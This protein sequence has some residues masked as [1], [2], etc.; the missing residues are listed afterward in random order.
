[1]KHF[2]QKNNDGDDS[3][4]TTLDEE[5]PPQHIHDLFDKIDANSN[6]YLSKSE[7]DKAIEQ[8]EDDDKPECIQGVVDEAFT[9]GKTLADPA[10]GASF[11]D[12][13]KILPVVGATCHPDH[14]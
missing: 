8:L 9:D 12:F 14:P 7:V 10:S 4:T 5:G 2:Q 3:S 1:M 6:G 11:Q 13:M